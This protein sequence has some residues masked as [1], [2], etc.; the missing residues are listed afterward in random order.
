[1][2]RAV[3]IHQPNYLPW[4]GFFQKVA[5]A[6]I[7]VILD[8][9]KFTKN[10]VIHRNKIRTKEG[11]TWLTIPIENKY[12]GV[13]IKDVCLPKDR[14]WWGKHWRLIIGN[15]GKAK[16]FAEYKDFFEEMYSEKRYTRL[17]DINEAIIFY[18]FEC[19]EIHPEIIRSCEL[20][21]DPSLAKTD[22]NLEIVKEVG[23]DVYISGMGGR[24][25]ME[26]EKF[27]KEG[28]EVKYFEFKPFEYPQRWEGF[29]PF[30]SAIDLL[31]NVGSE[32]AKELIKGGANL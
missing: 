2:G 5:R 3:A 4:I 16:Y 9:A 25:Y 21:L 17:Q 22:L 27:K 19:F 7:F 28:I 30:M 20:N 13:A 14:K 15:Y 12:K 26:E 1:M 29:E 10:G 11:W 8:V 23:G 32:R 6:E 31:F 24:K 18:L